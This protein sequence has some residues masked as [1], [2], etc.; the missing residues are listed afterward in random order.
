MIT[1]KS[2]ALFLFFWIVIT[3]TSL[4][5]GL[6]DDPYVLPFSNKWLPVTQAQLQN[7]SSFSNTTLSLPELYKAA[8]WPPTAAPGEEAQAGAAL[9]EYLWRGTAPPGAA[10]YQQR[11]G[12]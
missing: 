3:L 7:S 10:F 5:K 8:R 1:S 4:D 6:D 11:P 2:L 12:G 9:T